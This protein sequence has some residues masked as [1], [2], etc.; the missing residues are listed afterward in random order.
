MICVRTRTNCISNDTQMLWSSLMT[1][2]IPICMDRSLTSSMLLPR[3]MDLA[4]CSQMGAL[5]PFRWH[6]S[7]SSNLIHCRGHQ[8]FIPSDIPRCHSVIVKTQRP[9]DLFT[10]T[11]S[12]E[13]FTSFQDSSLAGLWSTLQVHPKDILNQRKMIGSTLM[14]TCRFKSF[15]PCRTLTCTFRLADRDMF[16]HF[17]G[18]EVGHM[19]MHQVEPWLDALGGVQHGHCS[20]IK[21][22]IQTPSPWLQP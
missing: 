12:S 18:G 22:Q 11:R 3:T 14:S 17:R 10:R 2:N 20:R 6:G 13:L 1:K 9:L 7:V 4:A 19:Y 21:I 15:K 8:D 16:M 5:S